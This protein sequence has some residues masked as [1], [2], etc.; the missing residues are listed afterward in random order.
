LNFIGHGIFE[1]NA[2]AFADDP[3][4]FAAAIAWDVDRMG[5]KEPEPFTVHGEVKFTNDK[6]QPSPEES[7]AKRAAP[8]KKATAKKSRK[9]KAA[10]KSTSKKTTQKATQ[11]TPRKVAKKKPAKKKGSKKA[12][13]KKASPKKAKVDPEKRINVKNAEP[14]QA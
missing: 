10:K 4:S 9:K 3:L 7:A 2:P 13:A 6:G 11:K 14:A 1:K 8:S 5:D 12:T